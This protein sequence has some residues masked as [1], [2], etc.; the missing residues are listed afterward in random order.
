MLMIIEVREDEGSMADKMNVL[1]EKR[2]NDM[3]EGKNEKE[4]EN[5]AN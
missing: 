2:M 4:D 5:K 1:K 3:E